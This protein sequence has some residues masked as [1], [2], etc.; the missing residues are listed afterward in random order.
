MLRDRGYLVPE[1]QLNQSYEKFEEDFG[2]GDVI[3]D[4]LTIV[5]SK[6][7][8]AQDQVLLPHSMGWSASASFTLASRMRRL[9]ADPGRSI[10]SSMPIC[11]PA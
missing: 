5:C 3:R 10:Y 7:N 11:C 8:N 9:A 1:D 2:Q 4:A 6:L